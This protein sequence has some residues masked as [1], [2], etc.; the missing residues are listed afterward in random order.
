MNLEGKVAIV[1]G[2]AMG[3]GLGIVKA[4]LKE[5]VKVAILD[6]ADELEET[7][8]NLGENV[9][10]YKIDIRDKE[11]VNEA[12][13]KVYDKLGNIDIIVNNAGVCRL[14]P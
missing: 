9:I 4:F 7:I 5:G 6:Y 8:K 3:N 1:T 11:V 2:G 13:E 14:K 12:V 10:G